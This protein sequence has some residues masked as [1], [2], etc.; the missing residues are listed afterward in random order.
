MST[1]NQQ[2]LVLCRYNGGE[3]V[4]PPLRTR[5]TLTYEQ[6][7]PIP[8][9]MEE[10]LKPTAA[11]TMRRIDYRLCRWCVSTEPSREYVYF[12]IP[13]E[14]RPCNEGRYIS[15]H[16]WRSYVAHQKLLKQIH[17]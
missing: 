1:E 4:M 12:Y 2:A 16:L 5:T 14:I 17:G 7:A 8:R 13:N 3:I 15:N 9:N 11:C 10:A 6:L